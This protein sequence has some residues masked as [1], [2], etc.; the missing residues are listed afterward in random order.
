MNNQADSAR[1]GRDADAPRI[2]DLNSAMP[3]VP[4]ASKAGEKIVPEAEKRV[5]PETNNRVFPET[6]NRTACD[7]RQAPGCLRG[8]ILECHNGKWVCIG[9][10]TGGGQILNPT[11]S[12]STNSNL[13]PATGM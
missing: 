8:E 6:N 11:E 7:D 3:I 2:E 5:F 12:P 13:L 10:A 9:P 4:G 1:E